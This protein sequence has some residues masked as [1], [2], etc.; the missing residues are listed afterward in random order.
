MDRPLLI[1]VGSLIMGELKLVLHVY[2]GRT[3]H[4]SLLCFVLLQCRD[5]V[6]DP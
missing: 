4:G 6:N 1:V 5:K 2:F 3:C